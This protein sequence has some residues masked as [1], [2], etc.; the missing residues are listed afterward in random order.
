[1]RAYLTSSA[2]I[3]RNWPYL[4]AACLAL[5]ALLGGQAVGDEP[6]PE[7]AEKAVEV[8]PGVAYIP[9]VTYCKFDDKT[10]LELDIVFP[11][12]G[13][14]PFPAIVFLH[15][16]GWVMGDRKN[17]STYLMQAAQAGYV[18]VAVSYRFAPQY[19]FPAALQDCKCAVRWLRANADQYK[20]AKD[21][22]AAFGFS[23]GGNLACMLGSTDDKEFPVSGGYAKQSDRVQAVVSFYG[24]SDL[25]ELHQCCAR[26][27]LSAFNRF[28]VTTAMERYLGG[29]LEKC[30][31]GYAK[32]SPANRVGKATPPTFLAY[33]T[34]DELVPIG[35]SQLYAEKLKQGGV[36]VTLLP[37]KDEG[38]NFVGE[39]E[40]KAL[41]AMFEFLDKRLKREVVADA[42][43][44]K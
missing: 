5:T 33:G 14:G 21:Q 40:Q 35:Q 32:A 2:K 44:G 20:I 25:T 17:M 42:A 6:K 8:P 43:S 30:K 23:A 4:F 1:V 31:E 27:E 41:K 36:D 28:L 16:G 39:A 9:D 24:I 38:H 10:T 26:E 12:R 11:V 29:P 37:V 15:G 19:P 34:K 18:G 3:E 7:K 13:V 22:I